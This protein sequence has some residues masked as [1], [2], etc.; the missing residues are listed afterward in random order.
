MARK[1][2]TPERAYRVSVRPL[3]IFF[4]VAG[5]AFCLAM[6]LFRDEAIFLP[7]FEGIA[8]WAVGILI[9]LFIGAIG[10]GLYFRSKIAWYAML[11]YFIL[12][13][14]WAAWALATVPEEMAPP[15]AFVV[16]G[17]LL[18]VGIAVGLY[19]VTRP[20]FVRARGKGQTDET[21]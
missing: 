21:G 6:I 10:V 18:N 1:P 12:G 19:F 2:Y 13:T 9:A 15:V 14:P 4:V 11:A 7:P 17:P 20:V 8:K 16:A 5:V 3:A